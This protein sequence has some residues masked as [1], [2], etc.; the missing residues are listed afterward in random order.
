M[1][2]TPI[3]RSRSRRRPPRSTLEALLLTCCLAAQYANA[4]TT[5]TDGSTTQFTLASSATT[6]Y[7]L[8]LSSQSTVYVSLSICS[9]PSDLGV[10]LPFTIASPALALSN[11]SSTTSPDPSTYDKTTDKSFEQV[12]DLNLGVANITS[13]ATEGAWIGVRAPDV[14]TLGGSSSSVGNWHFQLSV[15]TSS[16]V[17]QFS[18]RAGLAFD[19]SDQ[20]NALL[21][22]AN[23]S[24]MG[25]NET[26][27]PSWRTLIVPTT[28][29]T[30]SLSA[31]KC[32]IT[33]ATGLVPES[34]LNASVTTRGWSG[35]NRIQY[36]ASGLSAGTN[37]TA[38]LLEATGSSSSNRT[39][40]WGSVSFATKS[41]SNCR[42]VHSLD[43]CPDVAYSVPAPS[44]V[45]TSDLTAYYES[46]MNT[47]FANF[48]R[49]LTTFP[50]HDLSMG[51]YS[52]ISTCDNCTSSFLTWSCAVT[53]PRCAD[54][55][56][57]T[58]LTLNNTNTTEW[59]IPPSYQQLLFRTDPY[60][61]RTP[62]LSPD[63]IATTFPND[64]SAT[65]PF[66][67][68][69]VPPCL[70]VCNFVEARCPNM[71][72]FV[73]P[74]SNDGKGG[75]GQA[76]Y[77]ITSHVGTAFRMGGDPGG[78]DGLRAG[79]RFGNVYCNAL[80]TDLLTA[81]QFPKAS[82]ATTLHGTRIP[83]SSIKL[84]LITFVVSN[85]IIPFLF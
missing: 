10:N 2:L 40:L 6:F 32:F 13:P 44:G 63:T 49:S 50:C 57:G 72:Q 52:F 74:K 59:V 3:R 64:T 41:G 5:I 62:A 28:S 30:A 37:Y 9:P 33:N 55:P 29:L 14:S 51:A 53:M 36:E 56:S 19:D 46:K 82:T 42:L 70:D 73:C 75:T 38:W 76:G 23:Y 22:T 7:H 34:R 79:D 48:K 8:P 81:L 4:Q 80:S 25:D 21:T 61:S 54:P 77:G 12:A 58:T 39:K 15:S 66:P 71:L 16:P 18:S 35:G 1:K 27:P 31:S 67:Y 68:A 60:I 85:L 45:S 11:S 43:F 78:G 20:T 84:L 26:L 47:S 24:R 17:E 69:E 83:C 65:S